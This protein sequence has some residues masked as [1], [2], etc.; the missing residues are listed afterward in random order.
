MLT[1]R[2]RTPMTHGA[3][4]LRPHAGASA[5]IAACWLASSLTAPADQ[6]L[7]RVSTTEVGQFDR[8][9]FRIEGLRPYA[10][11]FDPT[12]VDLRLEIRTPGGQTLTLPAFLMQ[13]YEHRRLPGDRSGRDWAYPVG[14][15]V[16]KARFAPLA[17]GRHQALALLADREATNRSASV[18]FD[19]VPSKRKG[20]VRVSRKDPRFLEFSDNTPFFA[21]GQNLA[22]IGDQQY[23]TLPKA[24]EI[25][26]RLADNGANYLRVWTG[27]DD[28]ALAI[29]SRKSA[30]GRSWSWH[31]PFAPMPGDEHRKCVLL[32]KTNAV[33]EVNPSHPIALRPN[34]RY[35]VSARVRTET[36]A[37]LRLEVH[38][39][40]TDQPIAS[41]QPPEWTAFRHEFST[42]PND[43]WLGPMRLR[44]EGDAK[45]WLSDLSL[46]EAGGGPE[47]L[48]EA[49]VNR[50]VRGFYNPL[51]CFELDQLVTAAERNG[52]Y[53]QLCLSARDLYMNALNNPASADYDRALVDAR[54]LLRYAVAR[55]GYSTSVAAWEYWNE[56]NPNLP[57][58]RFYTELGAYL[59]QTDP[60]RHLRTTS[61]WGP[62]AKDCRH[63]KLDLADVHFYL[64]PADKDRL[65]DEVDAVLE[66]TR[67]LR[68]QA[69]AKPA[70][71]GEFGLADNQW[72]ITDEMKQ[73]REL[74]DAHNAL[75]ASALSGASGTAMFW[76][77]ERLDERNIYPL[78]RPISRFIAAVPWNSGQLQPLVARCSDERIRVIGLRAGD[79]A[80]LWLFDPAAAWKH[81]VTERQA[82]PERSGLTLQLGGFA[83]SRFRIAWWDTRN[84]KVLREEAAQSVNG[85]LHLEAPT[86][87]GDIA[88]QVE[89][90]S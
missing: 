23:V 58:D 84:G 3:N 41:T 65:A 51:D 83:A 29:E 13:D 55:W 30:W 26:A 62:S 78:Y 15:P 42:G 7:L 73:H 32:S 25:F 33:Q 24:E 12:E 88:C 19:C 35:V 8:I 53:L 44:L 69:P 10:H 60:F 56:M 90:G 72:R 61:T 74:V 57:T 68:E 46:K 39:A 43:Y 6:V 77:W 38:G 66:R 28:W 20:F 85:G 31:P 63:P 9:E 48:W 71:L 21:I 67:W 76:W 37:A 47:L 14:L 52:I 4:L 50:P 22:F 27:C 79:R 16:W 45:A 86:F 11:A 34:T 87:T 80:W 75:W 40:T 18:T 17:L 59:E 82:A 89:P 70:H 49:E 5:F 81:V 64:R 54:H 1:C 2:P 36:G